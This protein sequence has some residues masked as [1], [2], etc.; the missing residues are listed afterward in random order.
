M[1]SLLPTFRRDV[2][3][4]PAD[5][6]LF[7]L[8]REMDRMFEDL[9][10]GFGR[11][12]S[13]ETTGFLHPMVD[14][15]ETDKGLEVKAELPG[16]EQKDVDVELSEEDVLTIKAEKK[17]EKDENEKQYHLSERSYG[18]FLRRFRLPFQ[19]DVSKIEASFDKGVLRVFVPQPA[20]VETKAKKI[21]LKS[22]VH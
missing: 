14:V 9:S 4:R 8:W 20:E 21:P 7:G 17:T 12:L 15:C 13:A 18:T 3:M 10:R 6:D 16:V 1:T 19:T 11:T 5:N 2:S 22:A